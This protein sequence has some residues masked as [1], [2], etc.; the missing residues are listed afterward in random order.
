MGDSNYSS[1]STDLRGRPFDPKT[2]NGSFKH[3]D[4]YQQGQVLNEVS[5]QYHKGN[6]VWKD[7]TPYNIKSNPG[8]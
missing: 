2:Y 6:T 3:L 7:N 4:G 1:S 8:K 5:K